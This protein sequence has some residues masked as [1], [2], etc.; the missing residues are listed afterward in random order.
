MEQVETIAGVSQQHERTDFHKRGPSRPQ[1]NSVNDG[2]K[3]WCE[4]SIV[5]KWIGNLRAE[6]GHGQE[7]Q[8]THYD[9]RC[10]PF[11]SDRSSQEQEAT[12][13]SHN[14][15]RETSQRI[16]P[17]DIEPYQIIRFIVDVFNAIEHENNVSNEEGKGRGKGYKSHHLQLPA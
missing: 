5:E 17:E 15:F 3:S 2:G 1:G 8:R 16:E 9:Q 6:H 10:R 14:K 13:S 4:E 7:Y 11:S 12:A